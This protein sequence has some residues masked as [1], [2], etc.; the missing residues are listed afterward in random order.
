MYQLKD[1]F[2]MR[3]MFNRNSINVFLA[4]AFLSVAFGSVAQAQSG[5]K[6]TQ[7]NPLPPVSP[8]ATS[9]APPAREPKASPP[10]FVVTRY[11]SNIN[12]HFHTRIVANAF[13]ERLQKSK[14]L[15]VTNGGEM[16]RAEARKRAQSNRKNY[17][18]WL[19][20][21]QDVGD[22]DNARAG[23]GNVASRSL[24]INY[25]VFMPGTGEIKTQGRVYQRVGQ[26]TAT[27][28]GRIGVS[29]GRLPDEFLL[30][31]AGRETAERVLTELD[32]AP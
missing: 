18:V 7:R 3:R 27:S 31:E 32:L 29:T 14:T 19:S 25:I 1:V 2:T 22:T 28:G 23:I 30:R 16:N 8:S 10:P 17:F 5:R 21:E 26:V 24:V 4:L 12:T 15:N 11:V 6:S 13:L 9:P 20:L